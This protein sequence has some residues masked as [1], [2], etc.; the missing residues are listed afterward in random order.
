MG[1]SDVLIG[2]QYGDEG[3]ARVIDVIGGNYDII[4]RFNGGS[5]AGHTIETDKG[6]LVLHQ[7]PSG[8]FYPDTILYVGSGCV[9]NIE[10]LIT[11]IEN[12]ENFGLKI[13]KRLRLSSQAT[14]IQP[15]HL[16]IDGIMGKAIGTTK[17]GI[18][19][20]YADKAFRAFNDRILNVRLGD[21]MADPSRFLAYVEKNLKN[22][23]KEHSIKNVDVNKIMTNLRKATEEIR[24]YVEEDTLFLSK[25]VDSGRN[26]LFE[27]A[28]SFMLDVTKGTVPYVTSSNTAAAAAYVGGDLS[29]KHHRKTIGVAKAIMSRVGNGP[30]VSE[31]GGE[32]SE[33]YCIEGDG[34]LHDKNKEAQENVEKLLQSSNEFEIGKALRVLGN[35]YGSVTGRPRR[36]G[37]LDLVQLRYAVRCNGIDE[38]WLNKCDLLVDFA[39]TKYKDIP[40]IT[41][42]SLGGKKIDFVPTSEKECREI[43]GKAELKN[44]F[45]DDISGIR[46]Y[47]KLPKELISLLTFVEKYVGCNLLGVGVGSNRYKY[48]LKDSKSSVKIQKN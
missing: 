48:V 11:E 17:N 34:A 14:L 43:K 6:R 42:Y 16:L 33:K 15:H 37:I 30:F 31:F 40:L 3:K 26:V 12:I 13:S 27:G 36:V 7:V 18:G 19:P 10:K 39:K 47:E 29:P 22:V 20:A 38:L 1:Y 5:N 44:G 28:Q 46:D 8:V 2:L 23:V 25:K 45:V 9:I 32:R 4:A 41:E 21:V 35:E 24:P